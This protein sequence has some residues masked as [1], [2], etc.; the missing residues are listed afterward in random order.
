MLDVEI[1]ARE[2]GYKDR[3]CQ[4]RASFRDH[5]V[6]DS[7]IILHHF[8]IDP[9]IKHINIHILGILLPLIQS[10]FKFVYGYTHVLHCFLFSCTHIFKLD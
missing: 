10:L 7:N 1:S 4:S 2:L 6:H 5:S 9:H 3:T 8:I